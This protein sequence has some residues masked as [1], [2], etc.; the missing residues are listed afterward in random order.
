MRDS[1][2]FYVSSY[3]DS[4][5]GFGATLRTTFIARYTWSGIDYTTPALYDVSFDN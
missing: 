3:V 1:D 2:F 5:N 4:Q